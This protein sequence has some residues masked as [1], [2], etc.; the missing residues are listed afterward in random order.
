MA[1][2]EPTDETD[3]MDSTETRDLQAEQ[4]WLGRPE[5]RAETAWTE[6]L[7]EMGVTVRTQ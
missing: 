7:D 3:E 5:W 6:R 4:A 2:T 1:E